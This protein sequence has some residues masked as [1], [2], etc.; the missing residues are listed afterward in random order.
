MITRTLAELRTADIPEPEP[1][2]EGL[3]N[4]GET[5]LLVGRPKVGKSRLTNQ[6]TLDLTRTQPFLDH[7]WIPL[8]HRVLLLDLENRPSGVKVRFAKMSTPNDADSQVIIYAPETLAED[9]VNASYEGID[10]LEKLLTLANPDVLIVDTWRLFMGG[11]ENEA[12][13]VVRA[14]KALSGVRK[15][16]PKLAIILVHHLRKERANSAV[17]LRDDPFTWVES[18]S[19]HHALVG[20]VDA[21]YGLEREMANGEE[22]IVF[23]GVARNAVPSALLLEEDEESLLFKVRSGDDAAQSAMTPK[24]RDIWVDAK[25]LQRFTFTRLLNAANTKNK[26]AVTSTLRKAESHHVLRKEGQEYV[27]QI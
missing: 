2:V 15:N 17:H 7:Y 26:K 20:H 5:I 11:D 24:E 27:V 10:E 3:L 23:G 12:E 18:V 1:I 21:C 25:R 13:S 16:R 19:G 4:E 14:L 9:G 6:L 22:L 8:P